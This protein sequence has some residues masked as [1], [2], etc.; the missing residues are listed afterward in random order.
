MKGASYF[1]KMTS[2][3]GN[4][5]DDKDRRVRR[6]VNV[7]V[8]IGL[9]ELPFLMWPWIAPLIQPKRYT[10]HQDQI[11]ADLRQHGYTVN[12]VYLD[13]GW[14]DRINSQIYG[15]NLSIHLSGGFGSTI[16]SG[17]L[18]C[19][20]QKRN[21]WYQVA[22]LGIS[23]E[24]LTDLVPPAKPEPSWPDRIRNLLAMLGV[25]M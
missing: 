8:L 20:V 1:L 17:R 15:T 5:S 3:T 13:Q 24:E 18:E 25:R 7:L 22:M 11:T 9:L 2:Q 19:R 21:C 12:Q 10:S 4:L 16:V 6:W 23:R 14:P